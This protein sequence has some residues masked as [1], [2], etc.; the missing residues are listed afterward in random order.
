MMA[1]LS[2]S[3]NKTWQIDKKISQID[4]KEQ[5]NKLD[6]I[7]SMMT[8]LSKS[9]NKISQIDKKDPK[10]KFIEN[11]RSMIISLSQIDKKKHHKSIKKNQKKSL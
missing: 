6:K 9:I 2:Q 8:S 1:S 11:I 10:N 3:I 5:K 4:K 7:S